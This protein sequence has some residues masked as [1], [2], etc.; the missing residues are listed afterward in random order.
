M[1]SPKELGIFCSSFSARTTP[2][3]SGSFPTEV[4]RSGPWQREQSGVK[5]LRGI[6]RETQLRPE[7][8]IAQNPI[9][10]RPQLSPVADEVFDR[11]VQA[12]SKHLNSR[13]P[14]SF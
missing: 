10:Q 5:P 2:I 7:C 14:V 6:S 4:G 11:R 9:H 13:M 3:S 12:P 8:R 1:D